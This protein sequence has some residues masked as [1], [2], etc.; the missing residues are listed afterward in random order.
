[1]EEEAIAVIEGA[2]SSVLPV[3][4]KAGRA[5][6]PSSKNSDIEFI[7]TIAACVRPAAACC[8]LAAGDVA[9]RGGGAI[10][11]GGAAAFGGGR[12]GRATVGIVAGAGNVVAGI[13][14]QLR[15]SGHEGT[16]AHEI[17]GKRG[18]ARWA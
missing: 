12:F 11:D 5:A 1:M 8:G 4:I 6:F 15:Q 2:P 9:G 16:L 13:D 18:V 17:L 14:R 10:L 3:V 7:R